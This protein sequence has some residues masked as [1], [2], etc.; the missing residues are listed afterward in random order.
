[1]P[2]AAGWWGRRS[3][4][5]AAL[6]EVRVAERPGEEHA[7]GA[8]WNPGG[9]FY[10]LSATIFN[11]MMLVTGV[12]IAASADFLQ[13]ASARRGASLALGILGV[14][15]FLVGIFHGETITASSQV[16]GS[17]AYRAAGGPSSRR[18][19]ARFQRA[20]QLG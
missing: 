15:I 5:D 1:M 4:V 17:T 13:R 8:T 7:L 16:R 9:R 6:A 11:V 12:M 20:C 19:L 10:E 3:S 18:M 14:G 2:R